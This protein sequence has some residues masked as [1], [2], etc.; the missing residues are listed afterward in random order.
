MLSLRPSGPRVRLLIH[1][2][3]PGQIKMRISLGRAEIGM[4][5]QFLNGPQIGPGL[6]Q[7]RREG[8]PQGVWADALSDGGTPDRLPDDAIH[9]ARRETAAAKVQEQRMPFSRLAT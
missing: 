3:E 9:A 2:F 4:T 8:M 5:Q 1:G 7:V 6:K